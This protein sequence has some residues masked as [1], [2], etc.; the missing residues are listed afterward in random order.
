MSGG[1][2]QV[3]LSLYIEPL[4]KPHIRTARRQSYRATV[5]TVDGK[6]KKL[7]EEAAP[8]SPSREADVQMIRYGRIRAVFSVGQ[9]TP[10]VQLG[11]DAQ[12]HLYCPRVNEPII[13]RTRGLS[14]RFHMENSDGKEYICATITPRKGNPRT[15]RRLLW[16]NEY[17]ITTQTVSI[18]PG[19]MQPKNKLYLT[20]QVG[21]LR[22][23]LHEEGSFIM[24]Q[25][26]VNPSEIDNQL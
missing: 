13:V 6:K 23:I 16:K 17:S 7:Q 15:V 26:P 19:V 2:S 11:K 25:P 20:L 5:H 9:E 21:P 1:G 12:V 8:I 4:K 18:E 10:H 24:C 22:C 14:I 3:E